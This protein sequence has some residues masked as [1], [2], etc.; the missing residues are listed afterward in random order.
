ML[1]KTKHE[2]NWPESAFRWADIT[3]CIRVYVHNTFPPLLAHSLLWSSPSY[4]HT[5]SFVSLKSALRIRSSFHAIRS[6]ITRLPLQGEEN[7]E[8]SYD[9]IQPLVSTEQSWTT[10]GTVFK[11]V[12]AIM[13]IIFL[14]LWIEYRFVGFS[15][16]PFNG[17]LWEIVVVILNVWEVCM[18]I[19]AICTVLIYSLSPFKEE[20]LW[21]YRFYGIKKYENE[22][23]I[24]F[25]NFRINYLRFE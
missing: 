15:V 25:N 13:Y 9:S 17:N 23:I 22:Q 20:T 19:F 12:F 14:P 18:E 2:D 5:R 4:A 21:L 24:L 10:L 7:A 16:W 1:W 8:A 11:N 3:T 6:S